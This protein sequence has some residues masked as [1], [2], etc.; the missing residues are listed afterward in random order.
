MP[1]LSVFT[2]PFKMPQVEPIPIPTKGLPLLKRAWATLTSVRRWRLAED[3]RF[4]MFNDVEIVIP[5]GFEFDGASIPKPVY[6]LA[7][8]LLVLFF[9][10][11]EISSVLALFLA[12]L[13]MLSGLLLS[14]VGI[15]LVAGIIHDFAYSYGY[16]WRYD[17]DQLV[18]YKYGDGERLE[19]DELFLNVNLQV[20]GVI[21]ADHLAAGLLK[22]FGGVAW[23]KARKANYPEIRP[24]EL[25][26]L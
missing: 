14:P 9:I 3:W 17:G 19:W 4:V 23:D 20:N 24:G 15:M 18:K 13:F 12:I 6:F 8:V 1:N 7:G 26:Q 21:Y 16:L 5:K 10:G 2:L 22:M 25:M 11:I